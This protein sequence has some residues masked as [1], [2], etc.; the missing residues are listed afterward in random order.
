MNK[1]YLLSKHPRQTDG[2]LSE[3]SRAQ[4]QKVKSLVFDLIRLNL[5]YKYMP[6]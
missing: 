4:G 5:K 2:A 3:D 6:L 1:S